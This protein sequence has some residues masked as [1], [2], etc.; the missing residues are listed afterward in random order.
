MS[1]ELLAVMKEWQTGQRT[2]EITLHYKDGRLMQ[3]TTREVKAIKV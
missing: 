1:Q 3:L 2:G